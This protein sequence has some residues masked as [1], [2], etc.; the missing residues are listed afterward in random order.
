MKSKLTKT[1]QETLELRQEHG[2]L[3]VLACFDRA[4]SNIDKVLE[5]YEAIGVRCEE[6]KDGNRERYNFKAGSRSSA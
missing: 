6:E 5:F 3:Q 2:K 4:I 1:I